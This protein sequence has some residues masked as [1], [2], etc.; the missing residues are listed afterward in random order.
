MGLL[1][2]EA[3]TMSGKPLSGLV[4]EIF[5]RVGEHHY[6][7]IDMH[8]TGDVINAVRKRVAVSSESAIAGFTVDHLDRMDGAKYL[9]SNGAGCC[10]A[11]PARSR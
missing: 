6:G 1:L 11:L 8:L 7:R 3:M 5:D 2:L 4:Q 10:C 9:F